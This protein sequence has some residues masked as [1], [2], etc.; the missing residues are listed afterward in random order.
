MMHNQA[1]MRMIF[2]ELKR[3]MKAAIEEKEETRSSYEIKPYR[4]FSNHLKVQNG[5][6]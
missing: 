3:E 5:V 1:D 2:D 4:R 6:A